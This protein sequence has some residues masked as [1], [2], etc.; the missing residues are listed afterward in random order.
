[1]EALQE[2]IINGAISIITVLI[3][4]GVTALK[5]WLDAKRLEIETKRGR[6][7][8]DMV[9]KVAKSTVNYVEQV[10]T[11]FDGERKL[12]RALVAGQDA[13]REQGVDISDQQLRVFIESA[14]KEAQENWK[15]DDLNG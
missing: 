8:L 4:I 5:R 12:M 2:V 6:E 10:F 7:T 11:D 3:G 15:V 1:M 9:D 13:L 14:I